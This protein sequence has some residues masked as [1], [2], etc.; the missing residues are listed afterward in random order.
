MTNASTPAHP[1]TPRATVSPSTPTSSTSS[2]T[3]TP[4]TARTGTTVRSDS[5]DRRTV[6]KQD[7][8]FD[9]PRTPTPSTRLS[10]IA[11]NVAGSLSSSA[12]RKGRS[13]SVIDLTSTPGDLYQASTL[14]SS[15]GTLFD[16]LATTFEATGPVRASSAR[17]LP[18][19]AESNTCVAT[20]PMK[21]PRAASV[22]V[23]NEDN[24]MSLRVNNRVFIEIKDEDQA[25]SLVGRSSPA[26]AVLSSVP[27]R[28]C[29]PGA[30][31][32]LGPTR[33]STPAAITASSPTGPSTPAGSPLAR[34]TIPTAPNRL[35]RG[36]P[37]TRIHSRS[38][39]PRLP[40]SMRS[41]TPVPPLAVFA[42]RRRDGSV[43]PY[44][45]PA[46]SLSVPAA[47]HRA[48]PA[49]GG[50]VG[51]DMRRAARQRERADADVVMDDSFA[52]SPTVRGMEA[53]CVPGVARSTGTT[54]RARVPVSNA[55]STGAVAALGPQRV[56]TTSTQTAQPIVTEIST[57]SD[58]ASESESD[59]DDVIVVASG[60]SSTPPTSQRRAT[61]RG[62][63]SQNDND[64]Q[65]LP[66][67]IHQRD[68]AAA[69][70]P[71]TYLSNVRFEYLGDIG[72]SVGSS[73]AHT[74]LTYTKA[75]PGL[76]N[77]LRKALRRTLDRHFPPA[78]IEQ[79]R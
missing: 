39:A 77:K 55:R 24:D 63:A 64:V 72:T 47:Q 48:W 4:S 16:R 27:V 79:Q 6:E 46:R 50:V 52:F 13:V 14:T 74:V 1:N 22:A 23:K 44:V 75:T 3:L 78:P 19:T 18:R 33:P 42:A 53:A 2:T 25:P 28:S 56:S 71:R 37:G 21:A 41:P 20:L 49:L 67:Q 40:I 34:G 69:A 58:E 12:S 68:S 11:A 70:H 62:S 38:T 54:S 73:D 61:R 9:S 10:G 66:S 15:Q 26:P 43:S 51:V 32:S 35:R 8:A 5:T 57:S 36:T 7:P 59:H 17:P 45:R 30:P 31:P 60:R 29:T 65:Q 76:T